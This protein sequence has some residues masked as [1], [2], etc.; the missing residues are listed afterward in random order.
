MN[1]SFKPEFQQLV[2][3]GKK[4]QTIRLK[5]KRPPRPGDK[6]YLF[7][8]LRTKKCKRLGETRC[9]QVQDITIVGLS[10]V[11]VNGKLLTPGRIDSLA[12]KDGFRTLYD[13]YGFF[14]SHYDLPF[15]GVVIKWE[16]LATSTKS[17]Q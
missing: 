10:E 14:K 4:T 11:Y 2:R 1:L 16:E 15:K 9:S 8:G 5:G 12:R 3:E 17:K 7:T 13:F 6:L